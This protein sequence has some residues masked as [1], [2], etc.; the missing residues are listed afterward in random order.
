MIK[1]YNAQKMKTVQVIKHCLQRNLAGAGISI[2]NHGYARVVNLR[3]AH[4]QVVI[5]PFERHEP[6]CGTL[7]QVHAPPIRRV[8]AHVC[9][10]LNCNQSFKNL[11]CKVMFSI[12]RNA[13]NAE[14]LCVS[15]TLR[16]EIFATVRTS[17]R[18]IS[19]ITRIPSKREQ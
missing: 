2:M 11:T 8:I 13:R 17:R 18:G 15:R 3:A 16:R 19:V 1:R 14:T 7:I 10:N 12:A 9:M 5:L 4:V 6:N